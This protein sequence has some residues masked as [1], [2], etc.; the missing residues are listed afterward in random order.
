LTSKSPFWPQKT[1]FLPF[2]SLFFRS[3]FQLW[4]NC[5]FFYGVKLINSS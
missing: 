3:I 1:V 4:Q 2:F 5:V